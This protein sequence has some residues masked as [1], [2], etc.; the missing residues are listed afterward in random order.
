MD[1]QIGCVCP[2]SPHEADR[3]TL[4]D[5]L[6]F[7]TATTIRKALA[8]VENDD[9]RSRTAEVLAVLS[10]FYVL[11]GIRSWTLVDDKGKP[12]EVS[13]S[14][15]RAHVLESPDVD[16]VIEAADDLYNE[17]ILL[18]LLARVAKS[19]PPTPTDESTSPPM[20]SPPKLPK[21]SRR[22]STSTTQTVGTETTSLSLVGVSNI[23][24]SS[25]SAA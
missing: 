20:D 12:L 18:P 3:I 7:H 14:A 17:A 25:Q 11:M 10:E 1:V 2:G 23:S 15:I 5:K 22:S 24:Q 9:P 6:D 16:V 4:R 8:M 19:S 21:P 13:Q